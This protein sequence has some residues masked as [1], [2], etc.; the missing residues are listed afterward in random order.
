LSQVDG[1]AFNL[2][3]F[4]VQVQ[5]TFLAP[6]DGNT[7]AAF[8]IQLAQPA[9]AITGYDFELYPD[10]TLFNGPAW[11]IE[12]I[13]EGG[14]NDDKTGIDSG[15]HLTFVQS[16]VLTMATIAIVVQDNVFICY[17]NGMEVGSHPLSSS[18]SAFGLMVARQH[19]GGYSPSPV[20]LTQFELDVPA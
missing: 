12:H 7:T 16:N 9:N 17:V 5:V 1:K 11:A 20:Q 6:I 18:L 13:R 4:R 3:K 15:D 10:S 19:V 14:K 8:D 2:T